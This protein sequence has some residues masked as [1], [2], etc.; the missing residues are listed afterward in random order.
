VAGL[1]KSASCPAIGIVCVWSLYAGFCISRPPSAPAPRD[2][3]LEGRA[4]AK[5]DRG[6]LSKV[7]RRAKV[8]RKP[9]PA[10]A[11]APEVA[12]AP[13]V[14]AE[15]NIAPDDL[16]LLELLAGTEYSGLPEALA[17]FVAAHPDH[18]LARAMLVLLLVQKEETDPVELRSHIEALRKLAPDKGLPDLLLACLEVRQGRRDTAEGLLA[19]AVKK[20][21]A[22]LP[23]HDVMR[24]MIASELE[25]G[26]SDLGT[27]RKLFSGIAPTCMAFRSIASA[28]LPQEGDDRERPADA[29]AVEIHP[30]TARA[31]FEFGKAIQG[32]DGAIIHNLV[33]AA[34]AELSLKELEK[35]GELTDEDRLH[36]ERLRDLQSLSSVFT[37]RM[38]QI[39]LARPDLVRSYLRGFAAHGEAAALRRTLMDYFV[40]D[41]SR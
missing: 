28:F 41:L 16:E 22:W 2:L 18:I 32:A 1:L 39:L 10:A 33:G 14:P 21:L 17:T 38:D 25:K 20:D 30:Q 27:L 3:S 7:F 13:Q 40:G 24:L 15:S 37:D 12:E 19:L 11:A 9:A 26:V 34:I 36:R 31:V 8:P 5:P 35:A 6:S 23:D 4:P 29:G